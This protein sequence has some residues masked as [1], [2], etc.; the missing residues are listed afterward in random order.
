[1]SR[2]FTWDLRAAYDLHYARVKDLNL[3]VGVNNLTNR[4][5]PLD[6]RVFTDNNV[7]VSSYSPIGRLVYATVSVEL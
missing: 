3:A 4:M 1:M 7:D 5:P 6:P 2:Y